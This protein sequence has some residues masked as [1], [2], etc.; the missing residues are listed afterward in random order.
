MRWLKKLNK[1]LTG[2]SITEVR[3][4][5]GG[6]PAIELSDGSSLVIQSDDE[7]NGPG[8]AVHDLP[9]GTMGEATWQ[10]KGGR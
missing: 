5:R 8:V 1:D 2:L 4:D 10:I 9:D 3:Y 7:G 6:Y